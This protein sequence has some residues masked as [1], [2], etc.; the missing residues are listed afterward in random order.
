VHSLVSKIS[1]AQICFA[2]TS[3]IARDG[4]LYTFSYNLT[5]AYHTVCVQP[6]VDYTGFTRTVGVVWVYR[7]FEYSHFCRRFHHRPWRVP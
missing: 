4:I 6:T 7:R 5:V 2:L 3:G 1:Q